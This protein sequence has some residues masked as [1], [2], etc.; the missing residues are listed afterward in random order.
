MSNVS[1]VHYGHLEDKDLEFINIELNK[2]NIDFKHIN[3]NGIIHASA[4]Y[5]DLLT[6]FSVDSDVVISWAINGASWEIF[7]NILQLA[8]SKLKDT[9]LTRLTSNGPVSK[10]NTFGI[11]VK[12]KNGDIKSL[13]YSGQEDFKDEV[14]KTIESIN[15]ENNK[16]KIKIET[17]KKRKS[18]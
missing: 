14:L 12:F 16:T 10:P 17:I 8:Y 2:L 3:K 15:S 5:I 13:E 1:F 18:N 9:N 6:F 4:S 11:K 7:S